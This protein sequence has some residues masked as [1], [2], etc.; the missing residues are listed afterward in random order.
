VPEGA[1]I[2]VRP[3]L[4]RESLVLDKDVEIIGEGERAEI[5][6][7]TTGAHCITMATDRAAVRNLTLRQR[8]QPSDE[9]GCVHIPQGELLLEDCD[10]TS[11][12]LSCI[13]ICN[14]GTAPI[15]RRCAI[16]DSASAGVYVHSQGEGFL[17]DCQIYANAYAGVEISTGS[18]PTLR[19]CRIAL[20]R[21]GVVIR[22]NSTGLLQD[23]EI[24]YN[25]EAGVWIQES[26]KPTLRR[27]KI[28]GNV[29]QAIY[30]VNGG[31]GTVENCDL[32]GN[33]QGA[34]FIDASSSVTRLNN[35]EE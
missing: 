25:A 14:A 3:G 20:N 27:C 35:L 21:D 26:G 15:I 22:E 8:S 11:D 1:T 23:C 19:G 13:E 29:M 24:E 16:H 12:S 32:R 7:E 34:W 4:Y 5:V 6:L 30:V 10:L 18:N 9:K 33:T 31:R 2:K 28:T 17:E